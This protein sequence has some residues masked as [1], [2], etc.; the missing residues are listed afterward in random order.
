VPSEHPYEENL[1][2]FCRKGLP[3]DHLPLELAINFTS[4][5]MQKTIERMHE[6][7][8][9]TDLNKAVITVEKLK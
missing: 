3:S 2:W 4:R 9:K 6:S 1:P 8:H 5:M 7:I